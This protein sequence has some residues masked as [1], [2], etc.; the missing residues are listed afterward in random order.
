M[1]RSS[2]FSGNWLFTLD[3]PSDGQAPGLD[4][5]SWQPLD[6]PHDWS[7]SQPFEERLEGCTGYLPGGIGWYRKRFTTP[8]HEQGGRVLAVFDGVYNRSTVWLNGH[9]VGGEPYGYAPFQVDLT[10]QL[11]PVG[12]ENVL[13]VRVDH[14]RY[15]D[16]RWYTGSGIYRDV[17]LV[18]LGPTHI[19]E[20]GT[21]ITTPSVADDRAEVRID[22]EVARVPSEGDDVELVTTIVDPD[23]NE[24][25]RRAD[26]VHLAGGSMQ[27]V[28]Q[29]LEVANPRRWS[30]DTPLLYRAKTR[31]ER[32]GVVVDAYDTPFGIR[33]IRFDRD[34]GFFLNEESMKI[35]GVC[36]HHDAGAVGAAVPDDV[37]RRR[38]L[39]LKAGGCN[40]IR[41]AHNPPSARFLDLCDE[42]GLLMQDEFYDEWDNPKD[43]RRNMNEREPSAV[44]DGHAAFFQ[45]WAERDLKAVMRRDRNHPCVFQWSIGNEIEWTYPNYSKATGFFD[46]D[47]S[48]NYFWEQPPVPPEEIKR[49]LEATETGENGEHVCA[50]TARKLAKWTREMDTTRPVTAN[51]ILPSASH[52]SGYGDA[53][54]VIGYSYRR[55]MYD[56]GYE[57]YDLPVMGTEN[58]PQWHEWKA[59]MERDFVS[60][61]FLW[62]GIDYLGESNKKWPQKG[63]SSGLLDTAGFE[64]PA[65][66]LYRT[67]WTDEQ[68]LAIF[69]TPL[70]GSPYEL[71][72]DGALV[73]KEPGAWERRLWTWYPLN[74]HWSY[75]PGEPIL[76]EAY[77]NCERVELSLNGR[78]LGVQ[79]LAD[80]DDR[81]CRWVVH[82]E[83]GELDAKAGS[84]GD[85][86]TAASR[87]VTPGAV[88]AV[89]LTA[90]RESATANRGDIVHAVVQL[91]DDQGH[92]VQTD[93]REVVFEIGDGL[94]ILGVDNGAIDNVQPYASDRL[95]THRGRALAAIRVDEAAGDVSIGAVS[96][97]LQAGRVDV[98]VTD[99]ADP[100]EP[101][102]AFST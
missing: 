67:L 3:D 63:T 88:A 82:F 99:A 69:T 55:V 97:G 91:V 75:A 8:A 47:W 83:P 79:R 52:A 71:N 35:K 22:V 76:V 54:D 94:T 13:A 77:T 90:D 28:T 19:P 18:C 7:V 39:T 86:T 24:V 2:N 56:Y 78:A 29:Q 59:V 36:L 38:L 49:R 64:K 32:G 20:W 9:Q 6:L 31:L 102:I 50:D 27:T 51:C 100:S 4:D 26:A 12:G 57:H 72:A 93:N 68:H 40:A 48:G 85:S 81:V 44:T 43:K 1:I 92:P 30:I 23:G 45:D 84:Q 73:E 14:S 60:G 37:W 98:K 42:L 46:M 16:S 70:E 66:H 95:V 15:A 34:A 53:L 10:D 80:Q 65:Y 74:E 61:L 21:F 5:S 17:A 11:A 89:V 87:V 41:S 33:T 58:V 62:T 96:T 101:A 25:A